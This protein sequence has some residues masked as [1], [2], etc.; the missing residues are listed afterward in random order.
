MCENLKD[1]EVIIL[2]SDS[3][4]IQ[5]LQR[6]LNVKLYNPSI[7]RYVE[8]PSFHYLGWKILRGDKKTDNVPGLVNDK[9]AQELV[10]NPKL[11]EG[12]LAVDENRASFNLN[13]QLIEIKM[14]PDEEL[15]LIDGTADFQSLEGEFSKMEF[16]TMLAD[17]YWS[18]FK[19]V[20]ET[21]C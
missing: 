14:V 5:L 12:F 3:D 16:K 6:G 1:E 15:I 8:P 19:K 11:L 18:S 2:S 7:K 20:F 13:K 9:E 21:L 4:F 17:K 10:E